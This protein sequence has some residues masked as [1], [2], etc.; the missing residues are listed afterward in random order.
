MNQPIPGIRYSISAYIVSDSAD[1]ETVVTIESPVPLPPI[2]GAPN[3]TV[4]LA[5]LGVDALHPI[6]RAADDWRLMTDVEIAQYKERI[7]D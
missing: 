4:I 5:S 7:C 3:A 2:T 1:F 6:V